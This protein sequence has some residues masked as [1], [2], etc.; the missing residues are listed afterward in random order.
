MASRGK[1]ALV[2]LTCLAAVLAAA[3]F[4]QAVEQTPKNGCTSPQAYSGD[5]PGA[6]HPRRDRR[7]RGPDRLPGLV[8]DRERRARQLRQ[9]QCR[10][11]G[12]DRPAGHLDLRRRMF[13]QSTPPSPGGP[14][15][16]YSNNGT[17]VAP[18]FQPY[19]F[20]LP[21]A[22]NNVAGT[23]VRIRFDTVDSTYQGFRG[24]GIDELNISATVPISVDFENGV[25]PP[26]GAR[27]PAARAGRS[28]RSRRSRRTSA[29]RAR[30]STRA[31]D[32]ARRR[33]AAGSSGG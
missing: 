17:N 27:P 24:V 1:W 19:L 21:L 25:P 6:V 9:H 31:G 12:S 18:S 3:T 5:H 8:R 10:I 32:P 29:S 16:P 13:G 2:A 22:T 26:A 4:A 15:Q 33:R 28:G 23:Q 7:V 30:R 14:D 20:T 11:Q